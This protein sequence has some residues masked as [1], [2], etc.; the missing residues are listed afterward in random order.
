MKSRNKKSH[1]KLSK[2]NKELKVPQ[3]ELAEEVNTDPVNVAFFQKKKTLFLCL[4]I[5][6]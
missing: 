3:I 5:W 6:K 1:G 4:F 2:K